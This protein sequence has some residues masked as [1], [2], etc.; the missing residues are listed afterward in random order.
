MTAPFSQYKDIFGKPGEGPHKDRIFGFASIDIL[1]TLIAA[2][3]IPG[4][5]VRNF[6]FLM[7]LAIILHTLFGVETALNKKLGLAPSTSTSPTNVQ[8]VH[9]DVNT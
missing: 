8:P 6:I 1:F 7:I 2:L 3:L 5:K 4:D 9:Q